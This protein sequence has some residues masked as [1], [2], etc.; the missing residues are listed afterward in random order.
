MYGRHNLAELLAKLS[1]INGIEWIRLMYAYPS[2]FPDNVIEEI[3][4][5]SKVLNYVDIPLQHISDDVLKSMRRGVTA[6]KTKKLL[7]KLRERI[8]DITLINTFYC[9]IS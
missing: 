7:N 6:A 5:N 9:R 3:S 1:D 2:K 8:P 4:T